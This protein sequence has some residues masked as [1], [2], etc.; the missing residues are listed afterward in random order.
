MRKL[1]IYGH[2]TRYEEIKNIFKKLGANLDNEFR[3]DNPECIYYMNDDKTIS[4]AYIKTRK[5]VKSFR[6][7]FNLYTIYDFIVQ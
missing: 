5:N 2:E 7:V 6:R 3:F 4:F 1:A